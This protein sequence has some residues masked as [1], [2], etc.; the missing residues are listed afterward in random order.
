M[1][2]KVFENMPD[3]TQFQSIMET[4]T[5]EERC[6][7]L[8]CAHRISEAL[9][10]IWCPKRYTPLPELVRKFFEL[11]DRYKPIQEALFKNGGS[12]YQG[13][14]DEEIYSLKIELDLS[15]YGLGMVLQDRA[16]R[17][18]LTIVR[19]PDGIW[20]AVP[21]QQILTRSQKKLLRKRKRRRKVL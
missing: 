17:Q 3:L 5:T 15:V 1:Q 16:E 13:N 6:E 4:I 21:Q 7:L 18:H 14:T 20:D 9:S 8:R 11:E 2:E 10:D 19:H 12:L